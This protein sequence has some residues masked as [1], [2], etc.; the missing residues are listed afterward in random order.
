MPCPEE[1]VGPSNDALFLCVCG[2][3]LLFFLR[4]LATRRLLRS[5]GGYDKWWSRAEVWLVV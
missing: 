1:R 2:W 3:L 5:L 4:S